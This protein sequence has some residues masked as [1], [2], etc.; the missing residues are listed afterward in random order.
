MVAVEQSKPTENKPTT[1][2]ANDNKP[3]KENKPTQAQP[4]KKPTAQIVSA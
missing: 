4:V 1:K 3:V 2:P